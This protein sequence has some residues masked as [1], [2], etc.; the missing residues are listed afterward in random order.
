M[1]DV[2]FWRKIE[3][4]DAVRKTSTG[5]VREAGYYTC[6]ARMSYALNQSGY[7]LTTGKSIKGVNY[8]MLTL[9]LSKY[10]SQK[11][12]WGSPDVKITKKAGDAISQGDWDKINAVQGLI[13]FRIPGYSDAGGHLS[14]WQ[15]GN[16]VGDS[17]GSHTMSENVSHASEILLWYLK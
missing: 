16:I 13:F 6:A 15:N 4:M 3:F 12:Q 17:S 10:L 8:I 1:S 11:T 7:K 2:D 9:T 5:W 14:L